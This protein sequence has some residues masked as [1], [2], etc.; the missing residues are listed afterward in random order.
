M[1]AAAAAVV[2]D[3]SDLDAVLQLHTEFYNP[4]STVPLTNLS[5]DA[6][7]ALPALVARVKTAEQDR[8]ETLVRCDN[9]ERLATEQYHDRR[10]AEARL[11]KVQALH[12]PVCD[13]GCQDSTCAL[14]TCTCGWDEFPCP[15]IEAAA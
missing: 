10:R 4:D 3:P 8:D 15:T 6:I 2:P 7:D 9:F 1:S 5:R 11:A 13:Q 14:T 12:Q